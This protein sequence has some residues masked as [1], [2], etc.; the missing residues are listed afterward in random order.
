MTLRELQYLVAVADTAHFGR[1][2][3]ACNV[4]Q[5][6]LSM[7]LKK[8]EGSLGV[9]LVER[10]NK[11]VAL[12][13]A[14]KRITAQARQVLAETELIKNIADALQA[15]LAGPLHLGIIPTLAPYMVPWAIPAIQ[16]AFPEIAMV[17]HE[18]MTDEL[19]NR[20]STNTLDVALLALPVDHP[21]FETNALFDE[22]FLFACH[23]SS[24]LAKA[25][26]ISVGKIPI[27]DLLLLTDGH[28][29]RDQALEVCSIGG[30]RHTTATDFTATSLETLKQLVGAGSGCTLLPRMATVS[31]ES[32][33]S[34]VLKSLTKSA[35]RRIGLVWRASHPQAAHMSA[36]AGV[37]RSAAPRSVSRVHQ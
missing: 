22:P 7:Q 34:V 27:D 2:A 18:E 21:Q 15:P 31:V 16:S 13:E 24:P 33:G 12:T 14:G 23:R 29:F 32:G 3:D 11:R 25:K 35:S 26:S 4:S 30:G 17:V 1:A 37:I 10:T 20:L 9:V 28:C 36:L 19:L 5:P 6:T 8:L